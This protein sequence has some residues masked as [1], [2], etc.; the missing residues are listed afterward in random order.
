MRI[1]L[2]ALPHLPTRPRK[3]PD[4]RQQIDLTVSIDI[5]A[6]AAS[7]LKGEPGIA[8]PHGHPPIAGIDLLMTDLGALLLRAVREQISLP[9]SGL[10]RIEAIAIGHRWRGHPLYE[11]EHE[12]F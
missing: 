11:P 1:L 9:E 3:D 6:D 4:M 5:D 7:Y 12:P 2:V 8:G 10:Q